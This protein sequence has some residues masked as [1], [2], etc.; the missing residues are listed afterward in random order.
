MGKLRALIV[1]MTWILVL[2]PARGGHEFPIYPSY[3]PQ[4]VRIEP[5][6]PGAAIRLLRD[7]SIHAYVGDIPKPAA[8]TPDSISF[9]ESLGSYLVVAVNPASLSAKAQGRSCAIARNLVRALSREGEDFVFHP[10]PI[11]PFDA[12]YLYHFDRAEAV[13]SRYRGGVAGPADSDAGNFKVRAQGRLAERLV[14]PYWQYGGEDWDVAVEEV[15]ARALIGAHRS[16]V[17]GWAGPPWIKEGWFHA[18]LLLHDGLASAAARQ[19]AASVL[20]RLESGDYRGLEQEANLE[21][22]LISL[23]TDDCHKLV[24]GYSVR[25]EYFNSEFSAGI[26]NIAF[27]SQLGLNSPIFIRTV[28]LK[29]FPWNGWLRIGVEGEPLAAWNPIA[30][31]TDEGGRLI[32]SALGDPALL[33]EPYTASWSLN[34]I[35]DVRSSADQ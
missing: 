13:K 20:E 16:E 34:R 11:T 9:V 19:G 2:S 22:Q 24:A 8:A 30:G 10:Y 18:Y 4:E 25:R 12:D 35:S 29:D 1:L 3:Y 5:V 26:E 32:W 27:D 7:G 28:K 31:F 23:L 6:E 17:D 15:D 14:P 21:R 33:P